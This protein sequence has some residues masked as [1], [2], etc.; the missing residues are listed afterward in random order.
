MVQETEVG[1]VQETEARHLGELETAIMEIIWSRDATT[2]REVLESL[3]RTP[4]PGYTTVATVMTRLVDKGLLR[5]S[6]SGKT[7]LYCPT[8]DREEFGRRAATAAVNTLVH[9][10][11]D[12]ALAQFAAALESV[13][14]ERLAALQARCA[15]PVVREED[16]H[17]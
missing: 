15:P 1:M 13:D 14:P 3:R 9:D 11:G 2:V 7:D 16:Q 4:S 6:R 8:Y 17:A 10:F 12:V 5:R